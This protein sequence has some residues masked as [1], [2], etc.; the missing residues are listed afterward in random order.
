MQ[1][2]GVAP[3]YVQGIRNA[4]LQLTGLGSQ[5]LWLF[6]GAA[7]PF[8]CSPRSSITAAGK[9]SMEGHPA[10]QNSFMEAT[11]Q[12]LFAVLHW[13]VKQRWYQK[14]LI[15]FKENGYRGL[16][17]LLLHLP[18]PASWKCQVLFGATMP[19]NRLHPLWLVRPFCCGQIQ[20]FLVLQVC[21]VKSVES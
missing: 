15:R 7:V 13:W 12:K 19:R 1:F 9:S 6:H 2:H 10:V 4:A 8:L 3:C 5:C 11:S 17:Q 18:H 21:S 16:P 20:I 14:L